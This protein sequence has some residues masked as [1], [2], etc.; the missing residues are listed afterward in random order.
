MQ[1]MQR[2]RTKGK[3]SFRLVRLEVTVGLL[4]ENWSY[5]F[6]S[7]TNENNR[8]VDCGGMYPIYSPS[9]DELNLA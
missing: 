8:T 4:L 6:R 2:Y 9:N 5:P 7:K 1:S 3:F